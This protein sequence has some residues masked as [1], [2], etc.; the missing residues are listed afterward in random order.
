MCIW[1][2]AKYTPISSPIQVL[3]RGQIAR[4]YTLDLHPLKR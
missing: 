1:D 3:L 2:V 4:A